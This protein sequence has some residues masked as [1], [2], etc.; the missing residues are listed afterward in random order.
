[1]KPDDP[2][3]KSLN[4]T[5]PAPPEYHGQWVA[6]SEDHSRIVAHGMKFDEVC[7]A[8]HAAGCE[9]PILQKVNCQHFV[10]QR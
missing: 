7:E 9:D 10:G 3:L 8:A 6:W 5:P 1:M 2:R 4:L